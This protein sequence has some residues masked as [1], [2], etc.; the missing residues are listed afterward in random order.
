MKYDTLLSYHMDHGQS[1]RVIRDAN[2]S[3]VEVKKG[4][5]LGGHLAV[6]IRSANIEGWGV[7]DREV[8]GVLLVPTYAYD[9][10]V[11]AGLR[12]A[13]DIAPIMG[14]IGGSMTSETKKKSS[15]ENGRKGGRPKRM[16]EKNTPTPA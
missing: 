11:V 16:E 5:D 12:C 6:V 2:H 8:S 1:L 3:W 15:A 10:V 13:A 14:K 4:N 7:I 9:R